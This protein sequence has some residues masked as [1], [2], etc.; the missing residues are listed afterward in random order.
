MLLQ[1]SRQASIRD[2]PSVALSIPGEVFFTTKLV[3]R[4]AGKPL[5]VDELKLNN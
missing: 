2:N 1:P 5:A 4:P 3:C